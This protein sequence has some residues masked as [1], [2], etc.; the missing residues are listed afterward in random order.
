MRRR[1]GLESRE[2]LEGVHSDVDDAVD[3]GFVAV[4]VVGFAVDD[5]A[6]DGDNGDYVAAA[7][8]VDVVDFVAGNVCVC[9]LL[10]V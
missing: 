10:S 2:V 7:D 4:A 3:V 9:L 6:G 8:A 1:I 5:D